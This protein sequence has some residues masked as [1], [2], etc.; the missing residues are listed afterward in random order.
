M[1]IKKENKEDI[2]IQVEIDR[3][4]TENVRIIRQF[5]LKKVDG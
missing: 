4:G 2:D 5:K 1:K 3:H